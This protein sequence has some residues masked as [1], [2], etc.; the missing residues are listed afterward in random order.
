MAAILKYLKEDVRA[1]EVYLKK[2]ENE[3][4]AERFK[5][6]ISRAEKVFHFVMF[7]ERYNMNTK[8]YTPV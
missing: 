2:I 6:S 8:P 5:K 7:S 3:K 4:Y 1:G